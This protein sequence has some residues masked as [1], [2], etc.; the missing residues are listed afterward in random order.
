MYFE[1]EIAYFYSYWLVL[2]VFDWSL[3]YVAGQCKRY[4]SNC[5]IDITFR[6]VCFFLKL[7]F[8]DFRMSEILA[9]IIS[10]HRKKKRNFYRCYC[11]IW[12][13]VLHN[14]YCHDQYFSVHRTPV[15]A[16]TPQ[17]H[18]QRGI[19]QRYFLCCISALNCVCPAALFE[20]ILR[21]WKIKT[22]NIRGF[23][24]WLTG[25]MHA[26]HPQLCS[27]SSASASIVFLL[28]MFPSLST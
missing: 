23:T 25:S 13:Y 18:L 16:K 26:A 11:V 3:V 10:C 24:L 14:L 27:C 1:V 5:H 17:N 21:I 9:C 4:F 6:V 7:I 28:A 2:V 20:I 8:M 12:R 19:S 22:P 15:T